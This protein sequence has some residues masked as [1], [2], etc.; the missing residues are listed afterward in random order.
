MTQEIKFKGTE[1][2]YL[3]SQSNQIITVLGFKSSVNSELLSCLRRLELLGKRNNIKEI[4]VSYMP[5]ND[6]QTLGEEIIEK[7]GYKPCI[8]GVHEGQQ[9]K[10]EGYKKI[11]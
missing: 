5:K 7:L 1:I 9:T 10:L 6:L 2:E 11:L 8:L 4:W 3:K